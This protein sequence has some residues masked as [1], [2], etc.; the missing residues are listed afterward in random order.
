[1]SIIHDIISWVCVRDT[2]MVEGA[3]CT[4]VMAFAIL[5]YWCS[6]SMAILH[7]CPCFNSSTTTHPLHLLFVSPWESVI[8]SIGGSRDL[9]FPLQSPWIFGCL[10]TLPTAL[11]CSSSSLLR[12]VLWRLPPHAQHS[13]FYPALM[14]HASNSLQDVCLLYHHGTQFHFN[15]VN[16]CPCNTQSA[17]IVPSITWVPLSLP[18]A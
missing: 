11:P 7:S 14:Q 2:G 13:C 9:K 15:V 10:I 3:F 8:S 5:H 16:K 12:Q 17:I 1:M 6:D 4:S 18:P